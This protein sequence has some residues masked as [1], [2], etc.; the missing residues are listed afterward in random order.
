MFS[1]Y[2]KNNEI[3]VIDD[4]DKIEKIEE[5]KIKELENNIIKSNEKLNELKFYCKLRESI[6]LKM[7]IDLSNLFNNETIQNKKFNIIHYEYKIKCDE[8]NNILEN[9]DKWYHLN[10]THE[11]IK[12]DDIYVGYFSSEKINFILWI[13]NLTHHILKPNLVILAS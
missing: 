6:F 9:F 5:L 12:C 11:I 7:Q 10:I 4:S 13:T 2:Y 3:N 8:Y 1:W